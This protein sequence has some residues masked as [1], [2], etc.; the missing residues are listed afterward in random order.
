MLKIGFCINCDRKNMS[1]L[2]KN[3]IKCQWSVHKVYIDFC[4]RNVLAKRSHFPCNTFR[5]LND[6]T[7][8]VLFSIKITNMCI[9]TYFYV[10]WSSGIELNL[11]KACNFIWKVPRV[12]KFSQLNMKNDVNLKTYKG[13]FKLYY[14]VWKAIEANGNKSDH[15]IELLLQT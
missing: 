4:K 3:V 13:K 7:V 15:F 5:E 14:K 6:S 12:W 2:L 8:V 11:Q 1:K 9:K 10:F